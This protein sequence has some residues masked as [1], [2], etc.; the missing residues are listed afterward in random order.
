MEISILKSD[1]EF[2][3]YLIDDKKVDVNGEHMK[4]CGL[5]S[6]VCNSTLVVTLAGSLAGP[7][8]RNLSVIYSCMHVNHMAYEITHLPR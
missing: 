4:F 2:L 6:C 1:L 3:K 7:N 5:V 8:K